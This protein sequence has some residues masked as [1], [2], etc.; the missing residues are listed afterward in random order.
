MT[1]PVMIG[2]SGIRGI[3][4]EGLSP[5]LICS[6]AAAMGT[7]CGKGP[8]MVGRDS[9][10]SGPSVQHGVM[11]GLASVGCDPVDL[12]VC[13][14]PTVQ[15]AV[16]KSDVRGG[17]IITA[18][19]NPVE[20]N[21]LKLVRSDGLFLDPD[22]AQEVQRLAETGGFAFQP[23]DGQGTV[24]FRSGAIDD[25]IRSILALP[26]LDVKAIRK[27]CFRVAFDC[28]NGAGG[29]LLPRLFKA[30]NCEP[31]GIH[32]EP[33]GR[34]AHTPE[35]VPENLTGLSRLVR[36]VKADVGF[37]VDPD[38]DRLAVIAED[39]NPLGEEYTVT[40]ACRFIMS[41]KKGIAV[42]NVSTTRAA[43][44]VVA[45]AG[46]RVIRTPVG[47]IHVARCMLESNAVI[48][49]EGNGGVLLPDLHLGR[50]APMAIALVLQLMLEQ[51][52]PIS[53]IKQ[54]LPQYFM[55]KSKL[56]VEGRNPREIADRL[57]RDYSHESL[58]LTD[59]LKINRPRSWIHIRPSNTE[60]VLRVITEA[61]TREESESL[62][63]EFIR[64]I[65]AASA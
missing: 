63:R 54:S 46:G 45:K 30:L 50:D 14:T 29:T 17:I 59:G 32:V 35:P 20:W 10:V 36:K 38:A 64:K 6:F 12:G 11:A 58:D 4:G 51:N 42:L 56:S 57:K 1:K 21:A 15:L 22:E 26:F 2:I 40:L 65:E 41:R 7:F 48:G 9:R 28:V 49:G 39:G 55:T 13:P 31:A 47:E 43:E 24:T 25:H 37:A 44:E 33:H 34:F 27:R 3:V 62:C 53:L 19:H 61:Q 60:P 5:Q 23:W 52:R 16:M 18:S 8:V